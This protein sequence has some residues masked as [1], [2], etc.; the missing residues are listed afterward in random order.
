[1]GKEKSKEHVFFYKILFTILFLI[2]YMIGR[3]LPLYGVDITAYSE[4]KLDAQSVFLQSLSGDF[5]NYS[6]FILGMWPYMIASII[7]SVY[8]LIRNSDKTVKVSPKKTGHLTMLILMIIGCIQAW[9]KTNSLVYKTL[10]EPL[11][12]TKCITFME[13]IAGML[14]VVMLC[15]R[16]QK[17][18]IGGRM[19]VFLV[20][21]VGGM[22]SMIVKS[23]PK[24]LILPVAIGLLE[25]PIMLILETTEKRIPVQRVSIHNIYADKNYLAYKLN[26]VGIMPVMFASA[27][28]MLPVF[29]CSLLANT[30]PTNT[31]I[32]Y[33]KSQMTMTR[34]IGI[35]VYLAIIWLLEISFAFLTINPKKTAEGLLKSGDSILN[36]YAGEQTKKYLVG[37]ILR[38]S[39]YSCTI[40]TICMGLPLLLSLKG[41]IANEVVMLPSSIMM[42]TGLWISYYREARVYRNIDKYKPLV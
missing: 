21:I 40:L 41:Y 15:N 4:T 12:F 17:Y 36:V 20:N 39:I 30:F 10:D 16:N 42:T 26:P 38:F 34:P 9:N 5:N 3:D 6:V 24:D 13:I 27:V 32:A 2:I 18:G 22:C 14:I 8:M 25:I 31:T 28:F 29:L 23:Q 7:A 19:A 33:V 1:M 35:I 11:I 37:T